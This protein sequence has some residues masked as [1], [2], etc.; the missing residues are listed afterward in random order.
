MVLSKAASVYAGNPFQNKKSVPA[1]RNTPNTTTGAV[2]AKESL[3][4]DSLH[5][6]YKNADGDALALSIESVSYNSKTVAASFSDKEREELVSLVKDEL[7]VVQKKMIQVLLGTEGHK[8][9]GSSEKAEQLELNIPEYWNAE[10]TSQR[11]VDFALSFFELHDGEAGDYFEKIKAGIEEGFR[12]AKEMLG[13]VPEA[14]SNLTE[15]TYDL[16]MSKLD[17]WAQ[18]KGISQ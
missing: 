4:V 8:E 15:S 18:Q 12:Q 13:S 7:L 6:S 11:I 2:F 1:L 10:N 5:L 17:D 3:K 9:V 14:V 16:V